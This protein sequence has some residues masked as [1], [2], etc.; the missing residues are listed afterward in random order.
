MFS[1]ARGQGYEVDLENIN[2]A[3]WQSP[4]KVY[5]NGCRDPIR[6]LLAMGPHRPCGSIANGSKIMFCCRRSPMTSSPIIV[7]FGSLGFC[8]V[9][10]LYFLHSNFLICLSAKAVMEGIAISEKSSEGSLP[11]LYVIVMSA[12]IVEYGQEAC[13]SSAI[14][15]SGLNEIS[16]GLADT[17]RVL[18]CGFSMSIG[19]DCLIYPAVAIA[20]CSACAHES[21]MILCAGT[22]L[23]YLHLKV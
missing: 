6:K 12:P 4:R 19:V 16:K 14:V 2:R 15:R 17:S 1:I 22:L 9:F 3:F 7:E 18:I 23:M 10:R 20:G 5:C 13:V 11:A 21:R 8:R